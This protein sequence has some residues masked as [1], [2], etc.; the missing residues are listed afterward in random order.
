MVNPTVLKCRLLFQASIVYKSSL[1]YN[2]F[3][4]YDLVLG[5]FVSQDPIGLAGGENFYTFAPNVLGWV[6]YLGLEEIKWPPNNS[7]V[8]GTERITTLEKGRI[9]DRYGK[10]SSSFVADYKTPFPERSLPSNTDLSRSNYHKYKVLR[11]IHNV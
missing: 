10:P 7:A 2:F 1:H 6:D 4:Y 5:R 9:I 11:P 3:R 8:K